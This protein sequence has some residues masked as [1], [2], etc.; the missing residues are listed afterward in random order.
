MIEEKVS[1]KAARDLY[2]VEIIEKNGDYVIDE[3]ATQKLRANE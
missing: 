2:G 3:N 1:Q